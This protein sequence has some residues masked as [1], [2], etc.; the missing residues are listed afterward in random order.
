[1]NH[2]AT[3]IT[4]IMNI[5][6]HSTVIGIIALGMGLIVLTGDIDLSVGSQLALVGGLTVMIFNKTN[7]IP[8]CLIAAICIGAS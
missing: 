5:P 3:T 7:S 1:I 4:T 6:R 8:L 2:G